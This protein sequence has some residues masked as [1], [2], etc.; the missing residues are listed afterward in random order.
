MRKSKQRKSYLICYD[1]CHPRRL[2]RVHRIVRDVGFPIQYSVF[3]AE[4]LPVE[5]SALIK[6]LNSEIS[7]EE[8]KVYFYRL[9]SKNYNYSL[10]L[11]INI[12]ALD[13]L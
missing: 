1:I 3:E 13:L 8:D 9:A 12:D 6:K 10:G 2:R 11:Q 7:I 4:L 5:L